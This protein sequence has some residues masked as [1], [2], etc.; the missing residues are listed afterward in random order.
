MSSRRLRRSRLRYAQLRAGNSALNAGRNG[1][2]RY[3][4]ARAAAF[5]EFG[6]GVPLLNLRVHGNLWKLLDKEK[7]WKTL[8]RLE[9]Q[10]TAELHSQ[11]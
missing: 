3:L 11:S 8:S 9:T 4:A 5:G 7:S 1:R 6:F 2:R 10:K